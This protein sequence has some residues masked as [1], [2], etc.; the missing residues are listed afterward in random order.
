MT[1][2]D[3]V[4]IVGMGV[5]ATQTN[6]QT[7]RNNCQRFVRIFASMIICPQHGID[8]MEIFPFDVE[9]H[10]LTVRLD[11]RSGRRHRA[12]LNRYLRDVHIGEA[13]R[14]VGEGITWQSK[15]L[16]IGGELRRISRRVTVDYKYRSAEDGGVQ[17]SGKYP[18]S[19][20]ET[21]YGKLDVSTAMFRG[22][23]LY[24]AHNINS[25]S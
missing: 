21:Y 4:L 19:Q 13:S 6:Y 25:L 12:L 1:E 2:A 5:I 18:V 23:S 8:T 7:T 10:V 15:N 20:E 16:E 9:Q 17:P 3:Q 11:Q 22:R 24:L 14:L